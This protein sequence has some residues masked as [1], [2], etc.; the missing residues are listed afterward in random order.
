MFEKIVAKRFQVTVIVSRNI[1]LLVLLVNLHEKMI[2]KP[3]EF[4]LHIWFSFLP[5]LLKTITV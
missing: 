1:I 2:Q 5:E 4:S 3:G